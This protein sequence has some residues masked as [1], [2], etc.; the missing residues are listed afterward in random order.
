MKLD[1]IPRSGGGGTNPTGTIISYF[2]LTA[3]E[4]YL[5][6]DGS[7]YNRVDYPDLADHLT[8]QFTGYG[9]V[10]GTTFTVPDLRG[11][12]LRGSGTNSHANQGNGANVGVHQDGTEIPYAY[13]QTNGNYAIVGNESLLKNTDRVVYNEGERQFGTVDGSDNHGSVIVPRPTNT[14]I[15]YCIKT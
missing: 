11:E 13:G 14:S 7:S 15:L 10:G 3:P 12:F 6:C 5:V 1:V 4:G 8:S 9:Q 2:G